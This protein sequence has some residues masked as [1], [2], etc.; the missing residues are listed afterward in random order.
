VRLTTHS[1]ASR[2]PCGTAEDVRVSSRSDPRYP[3]SRIAF[4]SATLIRDTRGKGLRPI[5]R[6][7]SRFLFVTR[8]SR[9]QYVSGVPSS[10]KCGLFHFLSRFRVFRATPVDL[11]S[12]VEFALRTLLSGVAVCDRVGSIESI[13]SSV[14]LLNCSTIASLSP[15][16]DQGCLDQAGCRDAWIAV[17]K[18]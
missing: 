16:S 8:V 5:N 12:K 18:R 1:R 15:F 10:A 14:S 4:G 9:Q 11:E 2:V 13:D 6:D 17:E 7:Q 3:A